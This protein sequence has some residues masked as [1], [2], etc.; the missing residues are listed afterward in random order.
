VLVAVSDAGRELL[1][2]DRRRRDAWL[3]CRLRE[4]SPG[5]LEILERAAP[6]LERLAQAE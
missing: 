4:L 3:S 5:E 1:R 6:I 2:D